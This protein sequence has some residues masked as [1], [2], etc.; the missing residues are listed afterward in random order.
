MPYRISCGMILVMILPA[1]YVIYELNKGYYI[2]EGLAIPHFGM[3]RHDPDAVLPWVN[4][5][6]RLT[7]NGGKYYLLTEEAVILR[8][9]RSVSL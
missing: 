8:L 9:N 5:I 1:G 3:L 2:M 6:K 4:N 7:I